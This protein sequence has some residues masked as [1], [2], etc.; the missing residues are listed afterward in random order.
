MLV[1]LDGT[2]IR[3]GSSFNVDGI[4]SGQVET[5]EVLTSSST[6]I[7]GM[8][9]ANGVLIITTKESNKGNKDLSAI[10]VLP[11]SPKGFYKART[12]Y[13]PKYDAVNGNSKEPELRKTIYW[14]P[15]IKMDKDGGAIMEYFNADGP[16]V[17]KVTVEGIDNNGTIGRLVYRYKV[18]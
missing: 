15:E 17:Y 14:N 4:P 9:G 1:I 8:E 18:E 16:G 6:S 7:Y 11:I 10:G 12:F 5:V 13:S 2:E 3:P